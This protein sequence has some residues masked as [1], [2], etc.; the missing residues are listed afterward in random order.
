M[1]HLLLQ[2]Q[3]HGKQATLSGHKKNGLLNRQAV[4]F[5]FFYRSNLAGSN[6][7]DTCRQIQCILGQFPLY[8]VDIL[9]CY[10]CALGGFFC[11]F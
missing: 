4:I 3:H 2:S 6:R 11:Y 5:F 7:C 8:V 9:L 10:C 1:L